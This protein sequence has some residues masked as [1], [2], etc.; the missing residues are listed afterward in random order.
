M[1]PY[2]PDE[3]RSAGDVPNGDRSGVGLPAWT[4]A[5]RSIENTDVVLWHTVGVTHLPRSE[6]W[7]AMPNE[8]AGF[9]LIPNNFFDRSPAL[10]VP[11]QSKAHC[12]P[13]GCTH[14][15]PGHCTCGH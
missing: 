4:Q 3:L 11:G 15:L 9:S 6:D 1:T 12:T 7:P 2:A 5:N 13:E 8:V 10:D 14:C